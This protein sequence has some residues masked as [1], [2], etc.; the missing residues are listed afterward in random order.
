MTSTR[1]LQIRKTIIHRIDHRNYDTPLLS[2][3]DSPIPEEVAR[4]L[5]HWISSNREHRHARTAR[6]VEPLNDMGQ[7]SELCNDI[8]TMPDS[9]VPRSK[10]IATRLFQ[11]MS[12]NKRISPGDLVIC[13]FVE[14]D[15]Q[16]SEWLALLKVDT[17]DGFVGEREQ[18]DG[19]V[20]VVLRRVPGILPVGELQK[21][22]FILPPNLRL[23]RGYDL[24]VLDQQAVRYGIKSPVASF[25]VRDFL[26]CEV[27][28][29]EPEKVRGFEKEF[30]AVLESVWNAETNPEKKKSLED[31]AAKLLKPIQGLKVKDRDLRSSAEEVDL[32]VQ[33]HSEHP[34]WREIGTPFLVE[35][36]NWSARVGAPE[37]R[38]LRGKLDDKGIKS[39]F[40]ICREGVT[41][42]QHR[43]GLLIIRQ[44]LSRK[45][46][47]V[48][49]TDADLELVA[50]G[51]LHPHDMLVKKFYDIFGI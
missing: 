2:D 15:D 5:M 28:S 34:F 45:K 37:I 6:F 47:I 23:E 44:A 19:R 14:G 40:L 26:Q 50:E 49:I 9:F 8:L 24:V 43:D 10:E 11:I 30:R 16:D 17:E 46:Y 32:L 7:M 22:A 12:G 21:C 20:R 33:N 42:S 41:G 36:K 29:E 35:C 1:Q 38:D 39:A 27:G 18:T 31:L 51:L 25:F 3:K 48:P 13:T 4:L